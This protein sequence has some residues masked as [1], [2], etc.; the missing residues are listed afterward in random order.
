[1]KSIGE[2]RYGRRRTPNMAQD[3]RIQEIEQQLAYLQ[4][5]KL[6]TER[7]IRES[8]A[9]SKI[10]KQGDLFMKAV[11]ENSPDTKSGKA[12]VLQDELNK[13]L[14]LTNEQLWIIKYE[15]G[16][17]SKGM[18]PETVE[19]MFTLHG[20]DSPSKESVLLKQLTTTRKSPTK[21]TER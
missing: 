20:L 7:A 21:N 13:P 11:S 19:D 17:V 1:M 15:R 2:E 8:I 14:K 16:M 10:M 5:T 9:T 4:W 6:R 18:D 12:S 3:R